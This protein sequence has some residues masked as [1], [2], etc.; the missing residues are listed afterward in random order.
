MRNVNK[1]PLTH[2]GGNVRIHELH[3]HRLNVVVVH[4]TPQLAGLVAGL[5]VQRQVIMVHL[6]DHQ[7]MYVEGR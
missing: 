3:V 5:L 2:Q 1:T 4:V 7:E 6:N